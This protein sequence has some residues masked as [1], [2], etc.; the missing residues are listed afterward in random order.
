M[1]ISIYNQEWTGTM[2]PTE[3]DNELRI[4]KKTLVLDGVNPI[5]FRFD[6]DYRLYQF[7]EDGNI[8]CVEP[9]DHYLTDK[10]QPNDQPE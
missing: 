9:V 10:E 5:R 2:T 3:Q 1:N 6:G 7:D 8:L 4:G